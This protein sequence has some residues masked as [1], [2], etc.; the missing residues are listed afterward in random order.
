VDK[1]KGDKSPFGVVGMAGNV[2]EW[3]GTWAKNRA[4]VKGGSFM[5]SDVSLDQRAEMDPNTISEAI[6]FRTVSHTPPVKK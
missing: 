6:G 3:C 4:V 1:I 5:S 2:R